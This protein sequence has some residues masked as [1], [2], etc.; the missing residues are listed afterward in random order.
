M[1][2]RGKEEAEGTPSLRSY[3]GAEV[4][5]GLKD[6]R[7]GNSAPSP[8]L[9]I[10]AEA[11][12]VLGGGTGL[13]SPELPGQGAPASTDLHSPLSKAKASPQSLPLHLSLCLFPHTI[14]TSP[15]L[16]PR[17]A[18]AETDSLLE[19]GGSKQRRH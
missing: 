3:L 8:L 13:F 2:W 4:P 1:G 5:T 10:T 7:E 18:Q 15:V 16:L 9:S 11:V 14:P 19:P 17:V 6:G 12:G